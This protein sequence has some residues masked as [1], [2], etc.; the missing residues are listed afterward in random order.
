MSLFIYQL[1]INL[2]Q[3]LVYF[4]SPTRLSQRWPGGPVIQRA[5]LWPGA[6][7]ASRWL[8]VLRWAFGEKHKLS[9]LYFELP[10]EV[11]DKEKTPV[12][13]LFWFYFSKP[14]AMQV[15]WVHRKTL[16]SVTWKRLFELCTRRNPVNLSRNKQKEKKCCRD[17][18]VQVEV[19][20]ERSLRDVG[21]S[22]QI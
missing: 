15:W 4:S 13:V 3:G 20:H 22:L 11:S 16:K 2:W 5:S 1:K 12:C 10:K 19:K 21:V 17:G 8:V 6:Q 14:F 9:V 18:K 7:P